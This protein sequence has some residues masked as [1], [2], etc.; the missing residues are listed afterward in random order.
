MMAC[1]Y[2]RTGRGLRLHGSCSTGGARDRSFGAMVRSMLR[3]IASPNQ[4][5]RPPCWAHWEAAVRVPRKELRKPV[6]WK[7][8]PVAAVA[9]SSHVLSMRI[10]NGLG[11]VRQIHGLGQ[12]ATEVWLGE[13]NLLR[14]SG[15]RDVRIIPHSNHV[16]E[17]FCRPTSLHC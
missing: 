5:A 13:K 11:I 2:L 17:D 6:V 16:M 9:I 3:G 7:A 1:Q 4:K 10:H 14:N 8:C 12:D 15:S